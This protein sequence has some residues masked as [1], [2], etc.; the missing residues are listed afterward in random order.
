M[1]TLGEAIAGL[2]RNTSPLVHTPVRTSQAATAVNRPWPPGVQ[3]I[4]WEQLLPHQQPIA[5]E[6]LSAWHHNVWPLV[7]AGPVGTGKSCL[8]VLLSRLL[9]K[10]QFWAAPGLF[11]AIARCRTADS[12]TIEVRG[13]DGE[14]SPWTEVRILR[15][16]EQC[17][18]LVLDDLGTRELTEMQ[19][20]V[21]L[22]VL[23]R[24]MRR[25]TIVT[26]NLTRTAI[27]TTLGARVASRLLAGKQWWFRGPDQRSQ[28]AKPS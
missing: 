5:L 15:A 22:E 16:I 7:F 18:L 6:A 4:E 26:T 10:A 11:A 27:E 17:D 9:P 19:T 8:A 2:G 24:R 28:T 20:E 3:P 14:W 23:N 21:L 25:P 1:E 12:G 13:A